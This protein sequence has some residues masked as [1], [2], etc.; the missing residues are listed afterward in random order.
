MTGTGTDFTRGSTLRQLVVFSGPI[1][2]SNL[3]QTSF[4]L[5]DNLW[6]GNL[7]GAQALGAV[8][9]STTIIFTVLSFVIGMNNAALTILSQHKGR[10]DTHGL[11]RYLNTFIVTLF[12]GAVVLGV[13]GYLLTD[14]LLGLMGTPDQ[15]LAQARDYLHITFMGLVFL[16]GYTFIATV[17]RA[18]GDS[19]TPM[20]F[21]TLAVI[22]NAGLD[23][24]FISAWEIQGAAAATVFSQGMAF[25]YGVVHVW[26]RRL[27]PISTPHLPTWVEVRTTLNLGVPAGLQMSVISA[28]A[29]AV[30]S[31]V[32]SFGPD[33]VG[34]FGAE[35]GRA[36][37]RER[38]ESSAVEGVVDGQSDR[39]ARSEN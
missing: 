24:L 22:L 13:G 2:V 12:T 27:I 14:S 23:P 29:A 15:I 4:Q 7:L 34:G 30:M 37:W 19:T 25:A 10:G 39:R 9:I 20:R 32:A 31:V 28:G 1:M 17:L 33:V 35:I 36:S 26:R 5:V 38:V 6:V 3:L 18:L 21:I 16:F 11:R 8:A